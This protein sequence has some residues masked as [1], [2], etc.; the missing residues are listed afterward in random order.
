M[1]DKIND[2]GPAF[3]CEAE[4]KDGQ[5]VWSAARGLS[6]RD[7]FAGHAMTAFYSSFDAR[8]ASVSEFDL[9]ADARMFYDIA[10]AMLKSRGA[11]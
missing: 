4:W 6:L 1:T 8:D 2:G 11:R 9:T 3:P 5:E 7:W 10:D